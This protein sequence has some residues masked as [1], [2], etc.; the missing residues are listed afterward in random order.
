M[1][2]T[3][4]IVITFL[5]EHTE[6]MAIEDNRSFSNTPVIVEAKTLDF[7]RSTVPS[8]SNELQATPSTPLRTPGLRSVGC[9]HSR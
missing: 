1:L 9:G 7:H 2:A 8:A 3:F 5:S 6:R 4:Y